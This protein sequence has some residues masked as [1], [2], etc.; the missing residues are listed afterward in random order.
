MRIATWNVNSLRA[1]LDRTLAYL[2]SHQ[3][4]VLALQE[5]KV[6][7]ADFPAEPFTAAGYK[8]AHFGY[9]QWNGVAVATRVG[10]AD[11]QTSF[12]DQPTFAKPG[13]EPVLEARALGANCAGVTVWSLYVPHGRGQADPHMAYKLDFLRTLATDAAA[14][15]AANPAAQI[16]LVGDFNVAPLDTD[17]WDVSVFAGLTHISPAEREAFAALAKAGFREV[18]REHL[19]AEHLYTQW[20]YQALRF[21][22]N[23][24]MRIDFAYCSPALADRVSAVDII[25]D[26]RKGKGASDHVPVELTL[27]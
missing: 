21:P 10:L 13:S 20:D 2:E 7:D 1:R 17:V 3:I 23:E 24:G 8:V 14:W 12:P 6:K 5:T 26:E 4:D 11:V 15:L 22:R 16:A 27:A 25:R 9:N 19:P 18:T